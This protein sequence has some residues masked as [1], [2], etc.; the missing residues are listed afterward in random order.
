MNPVEQIE[1]LVLSQEDHVIYIDMSDELR[2]T[3]KR[4][5]EEEAL[6][7]LD[8]PLTE[9]EVD[10]ACL[11]LDGGAEAIYWLRVSKAADGKLEW[12]FQLVAVIVPEPTSEEEEPCSHLK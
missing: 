9:I 2:Q 7:E 4:M 10:C 8:E 3:Y 12:D 1:A 11:G 6:T 5:A